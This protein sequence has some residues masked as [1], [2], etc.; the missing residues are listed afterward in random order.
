MNPSIDSILRGRVQSKVFGASD[1]GF[2]EAHQGFNLAAQHRPDSVVHAATTEDVSAAVRAAAEHGARVRVQ[3]T[4]HGIGIPMTDG[5]LVNTSG[6][7][8]VQVDPVNQTATVGAGTRWQQVIDAA[9][10]YGGSIFYPGAQA[11]TVLHEFS[12]WAPNLPE[13]VSTSIAS[14]HQDP[15]EPMPAR[16]DAMILSDFPAEAVNALMTVAGPEVVTPLVMVEVRLM[17]GALARPGEHESAVGG[18]H[19]KFNLCVIGPY[20]PPLVGAVD[21]SIR[22]VLDALRPW[23][24]GGALINFQGYAT[25]INQ[26]R[27]AW[28]PGVRGKLDEL[29]RKWD[30]DGLFR[31]SYI[32]A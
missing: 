17:G 2:A 19:G 23:S 25:E 6:L 30:P 8:E 1:P 20:P 9:S 14:V 28:D 13:S 15:T 24:A 27:A 22:A 29:K 21:A 11:S 7:R 32:Y 5:I 18:R 26:V 16:D 12:S 3:A 31:F 10:Y 4:G